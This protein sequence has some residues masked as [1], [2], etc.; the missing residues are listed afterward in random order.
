MS[1]QRCKISIATDGSLEFYG[2]YRKCCAIA[3]TFKYHTR[4]IYINDKLVN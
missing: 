1:K 2:E 4:N 3:N